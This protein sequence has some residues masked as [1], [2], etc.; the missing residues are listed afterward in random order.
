V[1]AAVVLAAGMARRMGQ[2]KQLLP[3]TDNLTILEYILVQ[4]QRAGVKSLYVVTGA[5]AEAVTEL[6][7]RQGAL[8]VHNPQYATGEIT[9]SLQ[10]GLRALPDII[11]GA[12]V[13]LGDQPFLTPSVIQQIVGVNVDLVVPRFE[14]QWGHP[15]LFGRCYWA[16]LL[17]LPVTA[18]PRQILYRH[19][20]AIH[21]VDVAD[22]SILRDIDTPQD[23]HRE[24]IRRG[25][26]IGPE[27]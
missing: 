3:W 14:G 25:L 23:Y 9:S 27:K 22:D 7:Q 6:A 20:N 2:P 5:Y 17:T 21:F 8:V 16:E 13:V 4:L 15:I 24:R 10:A 18:K 12:V 26:D 19:E 1:I 11:T